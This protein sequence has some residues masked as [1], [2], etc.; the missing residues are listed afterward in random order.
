MMKRAL[1]LS[2]ML[3]LAALAPWP[4]GAAPDKIDQRAT[5]LTCHADLEESLEARVP[6]APARDA[7]CTACHNPHVSRFDSLLL[8]RPGPMCS[9]CHADVA[10]ELD[11]GHLHE[12]VAEG[13]CTSC[14]EAHGGEHKGLLVEKGQALCIT[15]H[16]EVE[17][18]QKREV[19]HLPFRAGQCARCH[20]PHASDHPGLLVSKG[21]SVCMT[22]HKANVAFKTAHQGYPV[23]DAACETCHDPHASE[24]AGLFRAEIHEPFASGR[25]IDCHALPGSKDPFRTKVPEAALCA[26]CHAEIGDLA[27]SAEFPHVAGSGGE[28]SACHNPHTASGSGLLRAAQETLCLECHNPGGSKSGLPGRFVSHGDLDCT[29]CHSPHGGDR[30]LLM[31]S[32]SLE[33]C[34]DCHSHQHSVAHP[35]GEGTIDPRNRQENDCLS[36]HGMHDAPFPKYLHASQQRDLC[37]SCHSNLVRSR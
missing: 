5:C 10:E 21:A 13:R 27:K 31:V 32:S 2:L 20:E 24:R 6:H 17:N 35:M 15:C 26:E 22:C 30:P 1:R 36:C 14:H 16:S 25:C 29:S 28:C 3:A 11:R 8:D 7:E 34:A 19:Q 37:V 12:P 33:Y 4:L 18:W 23:Q 9:E